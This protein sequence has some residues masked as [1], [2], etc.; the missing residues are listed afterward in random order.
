ME[1]SIHLA[2]TGMSRHGELNAA[3]VTSADFDG[4][5]EVERGYSST[6]THWTRE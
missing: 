5:R 3:A 6:P 4:V 1:A 2:H